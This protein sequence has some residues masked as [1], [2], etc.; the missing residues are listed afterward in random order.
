MWRRSVR[1]LFSKNGERP[2]RPWSL[3]TR[4]RQRMMSE[5]HTNPNDDPR[6][7]AVQTHNLIVIYLAPLRSYHAGRMIVF[8]AMLRRSFRSLIVARGRCRRRQYR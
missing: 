1:D 4:V 3:C 7:G 6:L 8:L 5:T 2:I